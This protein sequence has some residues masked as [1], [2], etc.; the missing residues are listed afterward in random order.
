MVV[1]GTTS[2]LAT[3]IAVGLISHESADPVMIRWYS[4]TDIRNNTEIMEEIFEYIS[5]Q[6][7][8]RSIVMTDK[9]I[10]CPHEEGVDYEIGESC[11]QCP[12]W[13]EAG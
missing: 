4:E 13:E 11:Q 2:K 1:Y 8:I 3:K 6:D 12:Y 9:I 7:D 5:N 10:G